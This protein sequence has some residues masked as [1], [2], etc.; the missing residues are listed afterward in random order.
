[1]KERTQEEK[2]NLLVH[3]KTLEEL[4]NTYESKK[5]Y[6][7]EEIKA[8]CPFIEEINKSFFT[9]LQKNIAHAE[10]T[11]NTYQEK[12]TKTNTTEQIL[13]KEE[14]LKTIEATIVSLKESAPLC[15]RKQIDAAKE[16]FD[17]L[18]EQQQ[19]SQREDIHLAKHAQERENNLVKKAQY[20]EKVVTLEKSGKQID[21][22]IQKLSET[23]DEKSITQT[24]SQ[25]DNLQNRLSTIAKILQ[26]VDRI[27]DLTNSHKDTQWE[28][29]NL[30]EREKI[31]TDLYRIFSKEIMIKVL[32]DSL[33]YFA[34][35]INNLLAKM[36]PFIVK[37]QPK[38]TSSDKLELEIS[39]HD[40]HGERTAKSLS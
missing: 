15:F 33:P 30:Q 9:T 8:N 25:I 24:K 17:D 20:E 18:I 27:K 3:K 4:Q 1:M 11:L 23:V 21:E 34:E 2:E 36:V 29:K 32:E 40:Q 16:Q 7:C 5:V 39:I 26:T 38:K 13:Q 28:I 37:F 6:Y 22:K 10:D 19:L 12:I 31:L 14:E 35:Y